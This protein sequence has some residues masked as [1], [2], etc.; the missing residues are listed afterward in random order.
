VL[1]NLIITWP[2]YGLAR[3]LFPPADALDRIHEV[4][5]LG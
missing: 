5:L 1:L 3:R 4:R 2:V